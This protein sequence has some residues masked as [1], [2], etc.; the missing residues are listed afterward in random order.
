MP[1]GDNSTFN[2]KGVE[3]YDYIINGL[4]KHN[5]TPMVTMFHFDLPEEL[6]IGGGFTNPELIGYFE[7]YAKTLFEMFGD[8]V[9]NWI[10]FNQ[11]LYYCLSAYG[12]GSMAPGILDSGISDY[13][14]MQNLLKAHAIAYRAYRNNF[15]DSQK[16]RVGIT[17]SSNYYFSKD[18]NQDIV[19]RALQF[20]LGLLANPIY[21]KNGGFPELVVQE[22]EKNSLNGSRFPQLDNFWRDTIK[23][24]ADFLGINYYTSVYVEE[25]SSPNG[26]NPSYQKD[27]KLKLSSNPLW[28]RAKSSWLYMVPEGLEN[29]LKYIRDEYDNVEVFIF[30]NG[31]SDDGDLLDYDRVEYLR[32]H[33]QAILNAI[34]DGCN[35]TGYTTW[36]LMDNFEWIQ[37][38]R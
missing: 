35:V 10:T 33:I 20:G 3:Y 8:R 29:L 21:S 25:E 26:T 12:D 31:W 28:K 38:Y 15:H 7:E 1:N 18:N 23:G 24:S 11:P 17:F 30:E 14:C 36:S 34:D 9:K 37:G 5:I 13:L 22:I 32:N 2:S 4:L 16:G 6:S 27:C 19:N